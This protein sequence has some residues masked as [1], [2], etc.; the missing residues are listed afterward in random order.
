MKTLKITKKNYQ[1]IWKKLKN[2][3]VV[4]SYMEIPKSK[5][6]EAVDIVK[7]VSLGDLI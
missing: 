1:R 7:N 4:S 2:N 3:F 5:F 6:D